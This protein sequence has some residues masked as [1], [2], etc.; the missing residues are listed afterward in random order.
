MRPST[1]EPD[2]I[3]DGDA[4]ICRNN[5]PL[6][7][8]AIKLLANDR[9]PTIA[10]RDIAKPLQKIM[11]KLSKKD[12]PSAEALIL[13]QEWRDKNLQRAREGGKGRVHDQYE[14]IRI[15]LSQTATLRDAEA[16]LS[17]LLEREGRIELMTGHKSKGLEF[18]NV[19]F[20]D[21]HLCDLEKGQDKNI[22]YV[23]ETRAMDKLYYVRSED[24]IGEGHD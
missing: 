2:A 19:F 20:L 1:W 12:I 10:G 11:K 3:Q 22:K 13:L 9:L 6:F 8:M 5:A 23:I 7:S 21:P 17:H 24:F 14:C 16:Y 18:E 15:M 4:I